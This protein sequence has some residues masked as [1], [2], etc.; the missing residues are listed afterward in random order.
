[1]IDATEYRKLFWDTL[2]ELHDD[3]EESWNKLRSVYK[4]PMMLCRFRSVNQSTLQQ[5]QEN[6]IYFSSADYYDDP[7]D[8]YFYMNHSEIRDK[9][10]QL[11]HLMKNG[12]DE[13]LCDIFVQL[14]GGSINRKIVLLALEDARKNPIAYQQLERRISEIKEAIQKQVFS[15][16]FCDN[17]KNETLWLKYADSHRGF[18]LNFDMTDS[19]VFP[20]KGEKNTC[21]H[22]YLYLKN[23]PNVYPVYYSDRKYDATR[24]AIGVQALNIMLP[25]IEKVNPQ[26]CQQQKNNLLWEIERISLIKKECHKN[27]QEW[28]MLCPFVG[29]LRPVIE[30]KPTSIALGLRM[31]E[32]E[33]R[34]VV[35]AAKVAGIDSINE[36]YIDD[37]DELQMRPVP[38]ETN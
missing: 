33:K 13:Q 36:M 2:S 17:P 31:P 10:G 21:D 35:S 12:T 3:S 8:T 7:F 25:Y 20:H 34:L 5:L 9:L 30:M 37:M 4:P 38:P 6:K 16:C 29:H 27:D 1:M 22:K 23:P 32:Y 28:R 15:V 11:E 18:V 24:Y 26:L 19:K 14:Y